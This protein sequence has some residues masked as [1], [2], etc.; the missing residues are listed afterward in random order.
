MA[1]TLFLGTAA[2][3]VTIDP[4]D[5]FRLGLLQRHANP[6]TRFR[7]M[8]EYVENRTAIDGIAFTSSRGGVLDGALLTRKMGA[9]RV[10][11]VVVPYGLMTDYLPFLEFIVGD[12]Q[13]RGERL[14]GVFLLLD[15]D[16][17]GAMPWTDHNIDAFLPPPIASAPRFWWRYLTAFQ[18][19]NWKEDLALNFQSAQASAGPVLAG[20]GPLQFGLAP[21][22]RT[23]L[24]PVNVAESIDAPDL[25]RQLLLL[26]SFIALCR[27]HDIA[28][29]IAI[30]PVSNR[31]PAPPARVRQTADILA[32]VHPL[33]DF[34]GPSELSSDPRSWTDSSHFTSK[35]GSALIEATFDPA[36]SEAKS[37]GVKREPRGHGEAKRKPIRE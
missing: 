18:W 10:L 20:L 6:N 16:L 21:A 13:S 33:T 25:R 7:R 19:R 23:G 15:A 8:A 35:V 30:S 32:S 26:R 12:K 11:N 14:S 28:L 5:V 37:F 27:R 9:S 2:A 31:N 1:A 22:A 29:T 4:Q 36:R 24:Q 34:S 17:F 3:N